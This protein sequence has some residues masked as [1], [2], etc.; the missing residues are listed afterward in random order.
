MTY[1]GSQVRLIVDIQTILDYNKQ[2][3]PY[4]RRGVSDLCDFLK[5]VLPFSLHT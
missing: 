5:G 2:G 1:S 4:T 3:F